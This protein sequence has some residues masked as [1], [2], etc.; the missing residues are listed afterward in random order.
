MEAEKGTRSFLSSFL[1]RWI[2]L[3][4]ITTVLLLALSPETVLAGDT[5]LASSLGPALMLLAYIWAKNS[6]N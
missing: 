2:L 1:K 4:L 5:R 3:A 6:Q